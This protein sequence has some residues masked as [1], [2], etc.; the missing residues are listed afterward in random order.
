MINKTAGERLNNEWV[1]EGNTT[2]TGGEGPYALLQGRGVGRCSFLGAQPIL[3]RCCFTT[4]P[5][6]GRPKT[7][8]G[9]TVQTVCVDVWGEW[10]RTTPERGV[11]RRAS[12]NLPD[13]GDAI[14]SRPASPHRS[15]KQVSER[16]TGGGERSALVSTAEWTRHTLVRRESSHAERLQHSAGSRQAYRP[17]LAASTK[18]LTDAWNYVKVVVGSKLRAEIQMKSGHSVWAK[19]Q[20]AGEVVDLDGL[21]SDYWSSNNREFIVLSQSLPP[22]SPHRPDREGQRMLS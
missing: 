13:E 15:A 1:S 17:P 3:F 16:T 18:V 22:I 5:N 21:F 7:T 4:V 11:S 10:N 14:P 2:K 20:E 8:P 9:V 19:H 12:G 6:L